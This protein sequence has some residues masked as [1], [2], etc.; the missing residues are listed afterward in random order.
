MKKTKTK[1][2][3]KAQDPAEALLLQQ[4]PNIGESIA[5][6]LIGIGINNP[7]EL[8]NRD[9]Y[10]L[11]FQ[12]CEHTKKIHD[13]CVLDV[14]ISAVYFMEGKGSLPWW[15]FT[16]ERKNNSQ[17]IEEWIKRSGIDKK[18]NNNSS[19][20]NNSKAVNIL[21]TEYDHRWPKVFEKESMK[22]MQAI[23]NK[24]LKIEHIGSTAVI[25]LAAKPVCDIM[26]SIDN[27]SINEELISPLRTIGY[28][29][30]PEYEANLPDRRFYHRGPSETCGLPNRHFHLHIVEKESAFWITHMLFR[31]YLRN[32]S[33]IAQE[34]AALKKELATSSGG[35]INN[36]CN[37]KSEFIKNVIALAKKEQADSIC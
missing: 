9:P 10:L 25:G 33:Q 2:A 20:N 12:L 29:Y 32:H 6:D 23:G 27:F 1:K 26:A 22:I 16:N 34:Y 15:K 8:K 28:H 18:V 13:P 17:R 5:D 21:I 14:F 31:D 36:Y 37:G 24:I 3:G 4:I 7:T 11:Y 30:V 19:S 35:N